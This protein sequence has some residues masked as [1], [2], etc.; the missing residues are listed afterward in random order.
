M[1][2]NLFNINGLVGDNIMNENEKDYNNSA[3]L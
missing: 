2:H 3:P 1:K